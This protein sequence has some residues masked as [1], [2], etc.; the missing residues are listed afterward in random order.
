MQRYI[1]Q[2][3]DWPNFSWDAEVLLPI[4]SQVHRQQGILAGKMSALGFDLKQEALLETL[5]LDVIKSTEIE[6]KL[7][8]SKWAKI[9]KCSAD[10]ALRDI[11]GLLKKGIL[12][13][14]EAGGRSTSMSWRV[15]LI[16]SFIRRIEEN[17]ILAG[18]NPIDKSL[19]MW[20]LFAIFI[21]NRIIRGYPKL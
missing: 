17:I 12:R 11:Q 15:V 7:T 21:F 18:K 14:G 10:T 16:A 13:A 4:L 9:A 19:L 1:H 3:P 8:S 2:L 20:Q 5:T 6:G